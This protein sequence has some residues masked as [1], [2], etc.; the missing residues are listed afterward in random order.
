MILYPP[1][2]AF[3]LFIVVHSD[4][5]SDLIPDSHFIS[6]PPD[7][8]YEEETMPSLQQ[9]NL[10]EYEVYVLRFNQV[11]MCERLV[12]PHRIH[13]EVE[14]YAGMS[15]KTEVFKPRQPLGS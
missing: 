12:V 5:P 4:L 13:P 1:G 11:Q 7:L 8:T 14:V 9:L 10:H 6:H 15:W 3:D 2:N